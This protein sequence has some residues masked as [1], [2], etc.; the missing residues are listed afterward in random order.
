MSPVVDHGYTG[1]RTSINYL[2]FLDPSFSFCMLSAHL[3]SQRLLYSQDLVK[4]LKALYLCVNFM[5]F[6]NSLNNLRFIHSFKPH[7][8]HSPL[9][10]FIISSYCILLIHHL[11]C[12]ILKLHIGF[13]LGWGE[14]LL[15]QN[16][17]TKPLSKY[18]HQQFYLF[19]YQVPSEDL[20][21]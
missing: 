1:W 18:L 20:E 7:M 19:T 11:F 10:G 15:I 9:V 8:T 3:L 21:W 2:H 13:P 17:L 14:V 16:F 5:G 4:T 12:H 6:L